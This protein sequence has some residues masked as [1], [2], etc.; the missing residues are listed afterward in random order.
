MTLKHVL[1]HFSK[2]NSEDLGAKESFAIAQD[3]EESVIQRTEVEESQNHEVLRFAQDDEK[4]SLAPMR[5]REELLSERSE[6]SNSGEGYK[7]L[8]R[9]LYKNLQN[10]KISKFFYQYAVTI[11]GKV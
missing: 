5:E 4:I 3:D 6:L 10:Q 1:R 9:N 7:T 2:T 11:L 8:L